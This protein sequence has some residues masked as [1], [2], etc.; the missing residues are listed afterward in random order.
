MELTDVL[1]GQNVK[2]TNWLTPIWMLSVGIS[3]GFLLVLLMLS[4]LWICSRIPGLNAVG[5]RRGVHIGAGSL[6]SI[7]YIGLAVA[8]YYWRRNGFQWDENTILYLAFTVPICVLLGFGF[9]QMMTARGLSEACGNFREGFLGWCNRVCIAMVVFAVVGFVLALFGG[10]GLI[11]FVDEPLVVL[12]SASR[13]VYAGTFES[14]HVV[15]P[16]KSGETGHQ[17]DVRFF[18]EEVRWLQFASNQPL[19]IAAQPIDGTLPS[20]KI[21]EIPSTSATQPVRYV[22]R[23]EGEDQIPNGL[24]TALYVANLGNAPA[25]LNMTYRNDPI[26]EQVWL[27]PWAAGLV[28]LTYVLYLVVADSFPKTFAIAMST[29]KTEVNQPL[30]YIVMLIGMIFVV[31]SIYIPYNTFGEDIKIYKDSGLT[32]IRVLA[33]FFAIWGASKSVAEEIEGRTALTVLSKPVG[34]RQFIMGKF[35]GISLA[36]GLVFL[37]LGLWFVIWTAYKPIYDGVENSLGEIRWEVSFNDAIG[38]V[39]G[40]FLQFLEVVIFVAISVA[41][42]TRLGILPNLLTCFSIYV[43]GHLTP[44]IVQSSVGEF[45]VVQTIG[46]LIAII[47]PVLNHFD[48]QAAINTNRVIPLDYVG[49]SMIYCAIYGAIAMLAALVL[50]EDRDLA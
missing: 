50:F 3:L 1:I 29:F 25:Q 12:N 15:L 9:W 36:V 10:F 11:K 2:V 6:L 24:V 45:E 38:L 40:I 5:N 27:I 14:S 30:F 39:P 23:G 13:L 16:S 20:S 47:F 44:L 46:N 31:L 21:Y 17:I 18:G 19:E 32:L 22:R 49:W 8:A 7:F 41:I 43:L 28:C 37:L 34:R 26:F 4:K 33:I 48:V 35:I 42:S